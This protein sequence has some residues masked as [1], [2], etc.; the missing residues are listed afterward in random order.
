ME[1][2]KN[3]ASL[4]QKLKESHREKNTERKRGFGNKKLE[5]P[6]RPSE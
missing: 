3:D 5:G 4:E 6:N 1:S 2:R